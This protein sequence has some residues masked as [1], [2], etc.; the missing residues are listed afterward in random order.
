MDLCIEC[1]KMPIHIKKHKLCQRC[2][3]QAY[4]AKKAKQPRDKASAEQLKVN[5]VHKREMEFIKNYFTHRNWKYEPCTFWLGEHCYFIPDFYDGEKNIFI[6]VIGSRQRYHIAKPK[7]AMF[8][9]QFPG[10]ILSLR[11]PDGSEF[12]PDNPQWREH[13]AY[14]SK[15]SG[16]QPKFETRVDI[17]QEPAIL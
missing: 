14:P 17:S 2:Y 5:S 11:M 9:E 1:G 4:R 10:M 8:G 13:G 3:G 6:E 15:V 12:N 16:L 7:Y